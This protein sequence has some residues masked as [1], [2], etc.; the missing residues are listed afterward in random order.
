[1]SAFIHRRRDVTV[2]ADRLNLHILD[3]RKRIDQLVADLDHH[4]EGDVGLLHGGETSAGLT[5][6]PVASFSTAL[7]AAA[8]IEFTSWIDCTRKSLN[9]GPPGARGRAGRRGPVAGWEKSYAGN[10]S[11]MVMPESS[12]SAVPCLC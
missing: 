8:C 10:G 4:L 6:P 12:R 3:L 5:L 9:D 2:R 7:S 1:M 11:V